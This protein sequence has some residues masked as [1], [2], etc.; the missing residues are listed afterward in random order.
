MEKKKEKNSFNNNI[1]QENIRLRF[2][3]CSNCIRAQVFWEL[4]LCWY[5]FEYLS[6]VEC[7]NFSLYQ[8]P[9]LNGREIVT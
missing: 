2:F 3:N 4:R 5:R 1:C 6:E 7:G 9:V 8:R